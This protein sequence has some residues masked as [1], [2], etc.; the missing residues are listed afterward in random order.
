MELGERGSGDILVEHVGDEIHFLL[1]GSDFLSRARLGATEAEHG[2]DGGLWGG[3]SRGEESGLDWDW[4]SDWSWEDW[5]YFIDVD[6]V[7]GG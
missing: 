1:C 4:D 7:L 5:L 2:H 3:V 6:V